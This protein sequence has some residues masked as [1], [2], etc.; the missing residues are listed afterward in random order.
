MKV[1]RINSTVT[2]PNFNGEKTKKALKN[3]A[4]AAAIALAAAVPSTDAEAQYF[5]PVPPQ[6]YY[7]PVTPAPVTAVPS[8]FVLGDM[9]N[10]DSEKS[11]PEVFN[12][13]DGKI[14]KNGS[15]SLG[16]VIEMERDNWNRTNI[17]PYSG[18]M[19]KTTAD[20]FTTLSTLY[21][22]KN[23]NPN[24]INYNEYKNIMKSY[25]QF[26]NV[27]NFIGLMQI[28]TM[29]SLCPP[30]PPHPHHPPHRPHHHRH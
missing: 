13:I 25:M 3:T 26:R 9:E 27:S 19:I 21:N 6:Y 1:S 5:V 11:M 14:K 20:Q 17:F 15:I 12:E 16:E 8:C 24:T 23:S 10:Y 28:L 18:Y 2:T 4:G 7:V 29:P 30:P 22:E